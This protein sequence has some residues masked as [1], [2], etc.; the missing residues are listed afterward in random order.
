MKKY[1][2][3]QLRI[4]LKEYFKKVDS[5]RWEDYD[6]DIYDT[7][8][9]ACHYA[10][11]EDYKSDEHQPGADVLFVLMNEL[12]RYLVL[13]IEHGSL[14]EIHQEHREDYCLTCFYAQ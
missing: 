6:D 4:M 5:L 12:E 7:Y 11:F 1:T 10:L 9:N 8:V 14:R 2:D 3:H 13:R